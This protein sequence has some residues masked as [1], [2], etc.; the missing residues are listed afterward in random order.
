MMLF[1]SL[2]KSEYLE[3]PAGRL[4]RYQWRNRRRVR[5][6]ISNLEPK[7]KNSTSYEEALSFQRQVLKQLTKMRRSAFRGPV[8]LQMSLSTSGKTPSHG[9]TIAKNLLDLLSRPEPGLGTTTGAAL[10]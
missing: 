1:N 4:G 10:F 8:A 5:L 2:A 9:H 3:T 6:Q 7:G